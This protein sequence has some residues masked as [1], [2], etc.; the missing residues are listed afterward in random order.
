MAA[1][2]NVNTWILAAQREQRGRVNAAIPGRGTTAGVTDQKVEEPFQV[3]S[4]G[5]FIAGSAN[6]RPL[7]FDPRSGGSSPPLAAN[8]SHIGHSPGVLGEGEAACTT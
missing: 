7:G 8:G 2:R 5:A 1:R 4:G 3:P 6:G